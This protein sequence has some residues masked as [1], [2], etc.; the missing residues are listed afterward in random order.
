MWQEADQQQRRGRDW[1]YV[2]VWK[3]V[4]LTNNALLLTV[5]EQKIWKS[6]SVVSNKYTVYGKRPCTPL[7]PSHRWDGLIDIS[8][9]LALSPLLC[10]TPYSIENIRR[11]LSEQISLHFHF[12]MEQQTWNISFLS[13]TCRSRRLFFVT[14]R[15]HI[16]PGEIQSKQ[17][18]SV[19]L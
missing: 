12:N 15:K 14:R 11:V 7:V 17:Q 8:V 3:S 10:G 9:H 2:S 4:P 5:F 1:H 16:S 18:S 19:R 13:Q 6:L